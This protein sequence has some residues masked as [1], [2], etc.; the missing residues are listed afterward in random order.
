MESEG[1]VSVLT[2]M[3]LTTTHWK[4]GI[5]ISHAYARVEKGGDIKLGGFIELGAPCKIG[6]DDASRAGRVQTI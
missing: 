1:D 6:V 3:L 2:T 4:E 5:I